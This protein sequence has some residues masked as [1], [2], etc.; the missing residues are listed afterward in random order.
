VEVTPLD[1]YSLG[2]MTREGLQLGFGATD[3]VE[4]RRGIRELAV[5][6]EELRPG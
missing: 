2:P 1:R 6:L 3:P 4:I 5:A